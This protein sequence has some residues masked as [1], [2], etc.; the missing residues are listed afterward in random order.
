M[1]E[2]DEFRDIAENLTIFL[3]TDVTGKINGILRFLGVS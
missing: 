2:I 1:K 3:N